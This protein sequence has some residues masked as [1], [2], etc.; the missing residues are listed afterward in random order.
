MKY[1]TVVNAGNIETT[2][3]DT[4]TLGRGALSDSALLNN[5]TFAHVHTV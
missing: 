4:K 2:S 3:Q 5:V 1:G